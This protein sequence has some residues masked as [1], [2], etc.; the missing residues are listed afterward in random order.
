MTADEPNTPIVEHVE[1]RNHIGTHLIYDFWH[2]QNLNDNAK[3]LE[4][5]LVNA[6]HA[7]NA[8]VLGVMSH[9]FQPHGVTAIVLLAESHISLHSW[10]EYNYVAIDV[11]TCGKQM[12]PQTAIA[13]LREVLKPKTVEKQQVTRGEDYEKKQ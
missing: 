7:S 9:K 2:C 6:A 3:H 11:F 12:E 8:T 13:H 5:V 1:T 4:K 10:P